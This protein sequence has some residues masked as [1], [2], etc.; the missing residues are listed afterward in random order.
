MLEFHNARDPKSIRKIAIIAILVVSIG[1]VLTSILFSWILP[2][3]A[4]DRARSTLQTR[5]GL[6]VQI[7]DASVGW[8]GCEL[9]G[10]GVEIP[11]SKALR[12]ESPKIIVSA[13]IIGLAFFGHRAITAVEVQSLRGSLAIP[14]TELRKWLDKFTGS[15]RGAKGKTGSS[16]SVQLVLSDY[17]IEVSDQWGELVKMSGVSAVYDRE[18]VT[19]K[20]ASLSM[21][22]TPGSTVRISGVDF[23][24]D[25]T[26]GGT[27][28]RKLEV[29]KA[30]IELA[31]VPPRVGGAPEI[32]EKSRRSKKRDTAAS[33]EK[34]GVRN[35]SDLTNL[36]E[37]SFQRLRQLFAWLRPARVNETNMPQ[38]SSQ[39]KTGRLSVFSER[40][41][42]KLLL[43]LGDAAISNGPIKSGQIVMKALGGTVKAGE[44]GAYYLD[45]KGSGR[46]GGALTCKL[47]IW[48]SQLKAE[49]QL[50]LKSLSFSLVTPFLPAAP[51]YE[52]DE[53]VVDGEL[54]LV[55]ESIDRLAITGMVRVRNAS[56]DSPRIAPIPVRD[57]AVNA[58]GKGRWYPERKRLEVT[59]ATIDLNGAEL[60]FKGAAEAA[61]DHYLLDASIKLPV[62]PCNQAVGAIPRDLLGELA[63]FE[64]KGRFGGVINAKIDS[65]ELDKSLLNISTQDNCVFLNVPAIADLRRFHLPFVHQVI[66]PDGSVFQM[67]TG[68]GTT[69][70]SYLEEISP[71]VFYAVMAHEDA[72][73]I[74]HRGF[75]VRHIRDA[76]VRN[77]KEKR[78]AVGAS[79]ITMQLVKNLFLKREKTLARKVQE[80]LLTWWLERVLEKREVLELYLNI[81]EYG[82][83][84]YGIR[85]AA[86]YYFG[87]TPAELSPAEAVYLSTILP[88]PKK[89]HVFYERKSV[90]PSWLELMQPILRRL[91]EKGWIS[92][93]A[94]EYGLAELRAFRFYGQGEGVPPRPL[95]AVTNP[96]ADGQVTAARMSSEAIHEA[97]EDI[98]D[99][100][101]ENESMAFD[102]SEINDN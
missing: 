31:A 83:G 97:M 1:G 95:P 63:G 3:F 46:E 34:A 2:G 93:E 26:K 86:R 32:E 68:P 40:L 77:L 35:G 47:K 102:N 56:L 51:W 76:L 79:T 42:D 61:S 29:E 99:I 62:M 98:R 28:L 85:N 87:R 96:F 6:D 9:H 50:A 8:T 73:F 54:D 7:K 100:T 64:W 36:R 27:K 52:A 14:D 57:I 60:R 16:K 13:N 4:L 15:E 78:Y 33:S 38:K 70:W 19:A 90:P 41:S 65:R 45:A 92:T 81:I 21:G 101:I 12:I 30:Q 66:E 75:S 24:L 59:E 91:G 89:Y 67:E 72:G 11:T 71:F 48:P 22:S 23:Q 58:M 53:G 49:G 17:Q 39:D 84:V 44:G 37:D 5:F 94:M 88:N 20:L 82:P 80:V 43:R 18:K 10:V 69:N 74:S 55:A 25:R